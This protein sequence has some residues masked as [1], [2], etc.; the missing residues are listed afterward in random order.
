MS[1]P[2]HVEERMEKRVKGRFLG[3]TCIWSW[4]EEEMEETSE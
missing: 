3:K 2:E 4:E 1:L